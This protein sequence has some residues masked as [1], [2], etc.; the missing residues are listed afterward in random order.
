MATFY[1]GTMSS[2]KVSV[3]LSDFHQHGHASTEFIKNFQYKTPW[4][5]SG[6]NR[7]I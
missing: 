7:A 5:S 4:K 3:V 2:H 6:G 1:E